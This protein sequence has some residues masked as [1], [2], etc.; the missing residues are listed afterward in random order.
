VGVWAAPPTFDERADAWSVDV[1]L[2]LAAAGHGTSFVRLVVVR[3]QPHS[4][5]GQHL[6]TP[7][8][9]DPVQLAETYRLTV[10]AS[11][12]GWSVRLVHGS[13]EAARGVPESELTAQVR[14]QSRLWPGD[15]L[16]WRDVPAAGTATLSPDAG[17]WRGEIAAPATSWVGRALVTVQET[18]PAAQPG[19]PPRH[20]AVYLE[21]V[22]LPLAVD[23]A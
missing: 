2:D 5:N 3:H 10:A 22:P 9:C 20:R 14:L 1:P 18:R 15:D 17:G 8:T 6:S 16:G 12:G 11:A 7:V 21:T 23:T 19:E 13:A 4:L